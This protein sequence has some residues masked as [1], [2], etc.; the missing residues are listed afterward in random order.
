[1]LLFCTPC[2]EAI[3]HSKVGDSISISDALYC[4]SDLALN[5][6]NQN[7]T[8]ALETLPLEHPILDWPPKALRC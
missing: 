1:M 8:T 2:R 3:N 4:L 6:H 7:H 5:G